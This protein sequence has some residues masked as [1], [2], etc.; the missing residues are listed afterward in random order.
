MFDVVAMAATFSKLLEDGTDPAKLAATR[1]VPGARISFVT[2]FYLATT[3]GGIALDL[4]IG[5]LKPGYHFDAVLLDTSVPDSDLRLYAHDN[6]VD[7]LQKII[8]DARR[9]NIRKVWVGG[10]QVKG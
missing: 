6:Q 2:A 9:P 5:L 1:G 8:W 7:I 4:P 3:A 10:R